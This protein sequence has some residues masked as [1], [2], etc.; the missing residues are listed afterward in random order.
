MNTTVE[1]LEGNLVKLTVTIEAGDVEKA[2]AGA[3]TDAAKQ[4]RVPGFRKGKA[5]RP[6]IDRYLGRDSVLADA[7]Q[8]L[9]EKTYTEA[10]D[11]EGLRPIDRPDM[12]EM[13]VVVEGEAYTYVAEV[14]V[15]PELG[16][17]GDW[18]KL[19]VEVGPK[20]VAEDEVETSLKMMADRFASLEPV[21]DRG[22]EVGDFVLVSFLGLV[23]G[24][25]YEGNRVDKYLY[26]SG[27]GQMPQEF[28]DA[29]TGAKPGDQVQAT[30]VIPDTSANPDFVGKTAEF[31]ITV[32]EIKSKNLPAFD[33]E[34]AQTASGF[35]TMDELRADVRSRLVQ[36]REFEH[37]REVEV[38]ARRALAEHLDG[39]APEPMVT[40]RRDSMVR[41]FFNNLQQRGISLQDYVQAVGMDPE[42]I[43]K[44]I[45]EEAKSRVRQDLALEALFRAE[46]MEVTDEEVDAEIEQMAEGAGKSVEEL[47]SQW[48]AAG[49]MAV[50][51]EEVMH[52]KAADWLIEHV[53]VV[54]RVE[55]ADA[56]KKPSK[57]KGAKAAAKD[58]TSAEET[59]KPKRTRKSAKE[60]EE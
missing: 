57:A 37:S 54:E 20:E 16:L 5:P 51:R 4:V 17:T 8:A 23:D 56:A 21:E 29:L 11:T 44:D 19:K 36:T 14:P 38:E 2:I 6:V 35:D 49:V 41:D 52:R 7:T 46:G 1:P 22:V 18:K 10:I 25:E 3:Y 24:V 48:E 15:R 34:F 30:F 50:F 42:Q 45:E 26:E 40:D 9:V 60:K 28:D 13:Q 53:E 47:R 43:T 27:R 39:E 59:A 55:G 32:H 12:G 58:D 31:D 33:D